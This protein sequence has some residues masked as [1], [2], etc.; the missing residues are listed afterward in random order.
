VKRG[1]RE[2]RGEN[3]YFKKRRQQTIE[4]IRC[5]ACM[6]KENFF[7]KYFIWRSGGIKKEK[8]NILLKT[9]LS[10]RFGK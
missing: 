1:R 2:Y 8:G 6:D 5:R 9:Y 7:K 10:C 3:A 4:K